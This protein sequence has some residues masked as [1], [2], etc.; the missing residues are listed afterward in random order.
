MNLAAFLRHLLGRS[1]AAAPV[2]RGSVPIRL[3]CSDLDAVPPAAKDCVRSL[4]SAQ[5]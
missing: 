3:S 4:K 2:T 1:P 5:Q